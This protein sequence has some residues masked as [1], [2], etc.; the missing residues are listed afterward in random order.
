ML[1]RFSKYVTKIADKE[2]FI[3]VSGLS[4]A[5]FVLTKEEM[6]EADNFLLKS[7][8]ESNIINHLKKSMIIVEDNF[9]DGEV[10]KE[11]IKKFKT[12]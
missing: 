2:K 11:I 7:N 12:S 9:N 4:G 8:S 5:I 6:K 10:A 3:L 1:M